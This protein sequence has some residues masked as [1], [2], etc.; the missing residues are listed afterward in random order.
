VEFFASEFESR[1]FEVL[2]GITCGELEEVDASYWEGG[3]RLTAGLLI[4]EYG[5]SC[6]TD[7]KVSVID[8][9]LVLL[10]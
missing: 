7:D 6:S 5:A 10:R 9:L 1:V 4:L 2:P 8:S 3:S